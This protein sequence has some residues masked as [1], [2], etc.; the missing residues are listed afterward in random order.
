MILAAI[1]THLSYCQLFDFF[2]KKGWNSLVSNLLDLF[3]EEE[4]EYDRV[5]VGRDKAPGDQF[6]FQDVDDRYRFFQWA[7]QFI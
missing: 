1:K 5:A 7:S 3:Q 4:D 2:G 6:Y